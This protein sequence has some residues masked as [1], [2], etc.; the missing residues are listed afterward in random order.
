MVRMGASPAI[1]EVRKAST[2]TFT[3][4]V[5][6]ML[7][8]FRFYLVLRACIRAILNRR[9]RTA[10]GPGTKHRKAAAVQQPA[11]QP[12]HKVVRR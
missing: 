8:V 2:C 11:A 9:Q 3:I 12:L 6:G 10:R 1:S 5:R 4:Y 7:Y